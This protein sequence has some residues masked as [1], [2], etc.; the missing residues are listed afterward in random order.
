V[1]D[2][3][4]RDKAARR[5]GLGLFTPISGRRSRAVARFLSHVGPFFFLPADE[6]FIKRRLTVSEVAYRQLT[7]KALAGDLKAINLLLQLADERHA[8]EGDESTPTAATDLAIVEAFIAR[9][10]SKR[11]KT[12]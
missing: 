7:E 5:R 2:D 3:H 10:L 9:N 12:P 8:A 1:R 11:S 4:R 6:Q